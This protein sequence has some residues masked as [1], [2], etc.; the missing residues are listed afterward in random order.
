MYGLRRL[1]KMLLTVSIITTLQIKKNQVDSVKRIILL[2]PRESNIRISYKYGILYLRIPYSIC[3][4][5]G[6]KITLYEDVVIFRAQ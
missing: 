4:Y 5:F 1:Q 3:V 6:V 2:H